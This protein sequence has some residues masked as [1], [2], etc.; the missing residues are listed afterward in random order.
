MTETLQKK[1]KKWIQGVAGRTKLLGMFSKKV[2]KWQATNGILTCDADINRN[3]V[4]QGQGTNFSKKNLYW[5][6][7]AGSEI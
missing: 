2:M 4:Y 7:Q 1:K 6:K 5:R 3:T